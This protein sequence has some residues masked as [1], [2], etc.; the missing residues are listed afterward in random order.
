MQRTQFPAV[1]NTAEAQWLSTVQALY[2][3]LDKHGGKKPFKL[4][5]G[6][7]RDRNIY[8]KEEVDALLEF[9]DCDA[10]PVTTLR[11]FGRQF[12]GCETP[13]AQ[14][15]T[16]F[17][18]LM[19]WNPL[20]VKS[21]FEALD[22]D[23][24]GRLHSTNELYRMITSYAFAGE[25]IT[26]PSFQA[27]IKWMAATEHIRYIGIRWGLGELG[28]QAL[29]T[30]KHID[31]DEILEDEEEAREAGIAEVH[32]MLA[33]VVS[34][35]TSASPPE[36]SVLEESP[37][38][39]PAGPADVPDSDLGMVADH[40]DVPPQPQTPAPSVSHRGASTSTE[41]SDADTAQFTAP[42]RTQAVPK[43][44]SGLLSL[45]PAWFPAGPS[46]GEI[47]AVAFGFDAKQYGADPA[48]FSFRLACAAR[49]VVSGVPQDACLA[50]FKHLDVE[51]AF[52]RYFTKKRA[53][54][55]ILAGLGWLDDSPYRAAVGWVLLD[56][57]RLRQLLEDRPGYPDQLEQKGP[58]DALYSVH[59]ELFRGVPD[60]TAAWY[61]REM[62]KLELWER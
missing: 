54:E 49:L 32:P 60:G 61:A 10:K 29:T 16:M 9:L 23:G 1:P 22:R 31:V 43:T 28:K 48:L 14:K 5:R 46:R 36:V 3:E 37:A 19:G 39:V 58:A 57:M 42:I 38:E 13:E 6:W 21:V 27:W 56:F 2:S 7:M 55:E 24:G 15:T 35:P 50:L 11:H 53:W 33:G 26:L 41:V 52:E 47:D 30:I 4:F 44:Q 45:Q 20:L 34:A 17:R 62:T 12:L 59:H 25:H 18:W 8:L 51:R 40:P